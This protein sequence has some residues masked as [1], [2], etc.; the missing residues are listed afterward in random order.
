MNPS[1]S[2]PPVESP[3]GMRVIGIFLLFGAATAFLA[4]ISLVWHGTRLDRMWRLNPRAYKEL[5]RFGKAAGIAFLPLSVA[6]AL[7]AMGWF[8]R[9]LWGWWLTVAIIAIQVL[10]DLVNM[11]RGQFLGGGVGV[12]IA[13]VFLI[14][15]LQGKV[16]NIF[17]GATRG[18]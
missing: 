12:V 3:R 5:A 7:A 10:G 18:K 6:L 1:S 8:K 15:L 4:G 9:R 2:S 13:S 11:I 14:Y 16:K 17:V